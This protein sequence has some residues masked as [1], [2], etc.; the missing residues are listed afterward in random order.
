[1][2]IFGSFEIGRKALRVQHKGMEVSGQNVANA[3]TPGYSR[4]RTEMAAVV[5]PI[6]SG[7]SMAPGRGVVITD[8]LRVRSEFYHAQMV[9]TGSH[10]AY[11]EMRREAFQGME[12]IL[13]EPDDYGINKYLGDFFDTWQE[14]SSSPEDIAVRSGLAENAVSLTKSV[15]DVYLR[16]EDTRLD[17]TGELYMRV[18]EVNRMADTIAEINDKLRFI[19]ALQQKSNELLDQLDLAIEDLA[20]L[21]DIRVHHK[22]NGT[23]EIFAGGRIMVQENQAFHVSVKAGGSD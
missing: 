4:Q 7:P 20:K 11:W 1:M 19:G 6:V 5:P 23:V 13:M 2:T 12:A 10:K 18:D 16:L 15:E 9:S 22:A 14:L 8:I 21:V 3:N 17:L